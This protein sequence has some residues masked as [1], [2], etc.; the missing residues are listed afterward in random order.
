MKEKVEEKGRV[1]VREREKKERERE[2]KEREE[3]E[4]RLREIER[5]FAHAKQLRVFHSQF[6]NLVDADNGLRQGEL[7]GAVH[8][9]VHGQRTDLRDRDLACCVWC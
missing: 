5:D 8:S 9:R 2:K 7:D 3:K 6:S 1:C 4:E